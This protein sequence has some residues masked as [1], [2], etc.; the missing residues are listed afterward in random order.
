MQESAESALG[1]VRKLQDLV[2]TG[3]LQPGP[4]HLAE[5]V[6]HAADVL[7]LRQRHGGPRVEV[8][9]MVDGAPPVLGTVSELSYLF[10]TLLFN[11]RDAMPEGGRIE[12]RTERSRDRV[13]VV[14]ADEGAGIPRDDLP[15]LFQPFFSTKG[16][17]GTGLGLWLAQSTMRRLGG[18]IVARNG[19][20]RGAEFELDFK[21]AA[22]GPLTQARAPGRRSVPSARSS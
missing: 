16:A 21:V 3:P 13:R 6:R 17:E 2:R 15:R 11:A 12:V 4:V 18:S 20:E 9:A 7:Q 1:S 19:K 8:H 14:V 10:I 22:D 5:V